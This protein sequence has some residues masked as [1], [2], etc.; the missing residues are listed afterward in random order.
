MKEDLMFSH[1]GNG[2]SVCDRNQ[3]ENR[4]YKTVAHINIM[5]EVRLYDKGLSKEAIAEIEKFSK[6][7]DGNISATQDQKV[8]SVRKKGNR[9]YFVVFEDVFSF[10]KTSRQVELTAAQFETA[11]KQRDSGEVV[12]NKTEGGIHWQLKIKSVV[13]L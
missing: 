12:V 5:R 13:C 3:E 9:L 8:F 6:T 1:M 2:I 11:K 4:D 7:H 10:A